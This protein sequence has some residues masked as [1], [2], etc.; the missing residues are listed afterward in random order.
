MTQQTKTIVFIGVGLLLLFL[1]YKFVIKKPVEVPTGTGEPIVNNNV[2][3]EGTIITLPTRDEL[4][5][6]F[7]KLTQDYGPQMAKI[8]ERIYRLE[9]AHFTSGQFK[10]SNSAG[11]LAHGNNYP[12]GWAAQRNLW[13][14]DYSMRPVGIVTFNVGGKDF[15]YLQFANFYAGARALGEYLKKYR[16]G[17]WNTTDPI[18]QQNYENKLSAINTQYT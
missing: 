1:V 16:P 9:T 18:G 17:R 15:K 8:I 2:G 6:A 5:V 4:Q 11:M 13:D 10:K 14:N 3:N 12:Y 7:S